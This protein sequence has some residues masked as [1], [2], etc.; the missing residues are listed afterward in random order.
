MDASPGLPQ[1]SNQVVILMELL[2]RWRCER[3]RGTLIPC[4]SCESRGYIDR[5]LPYELVQGLKPV[6]WVI[7]GRRNPKPPIPDTRSA[8]T[9]RNIHVI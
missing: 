7:M 5:W 2:L 4:L 6:T 1:V 3:C 8:S 9:S